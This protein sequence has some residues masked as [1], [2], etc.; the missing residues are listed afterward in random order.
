M[1]KT[2]VLIIAIMT[3]LGSS[4]VF[5]YGDYYKGSKRGWYWF[6]QRK[7]P[8]K[9]EEGKQE[10][11]LVSN[12]NATEELQRFS[13]ELDEAKAAMI[14]RPNIENTAKFIEYQ[15]EMFAKAD[16]VTENWQNA[17]LVYPHLNIA[18]D[19]PISHAGAKIK[20]RAEAE[21][22]KQLLNA[23]SK[24]FI[25]LFFYEGN[26]I[27]CGHFAEVLEVFAK[28]YGFKVS[29]VTIDGKQIS[30]FPSSRREDLV[31]KL[32]VRYF[33][34]VYAYSES[35][36]VVVPISSEFL[37]IDELENHAVYV[38]SKLKERL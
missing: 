10:E 18:R 6:E 32:N 1:N 25:L 14:M 5:G 27:Y 30:K 22:N 31:S 17:M 33:P 4:E 38:A 13:Q 35:L 3:I 8:A 34:S 11:K 15:N 28:R 37:A 36:G 16:V 9:E 24:K 19:I 26:C 23:F 21:S 7:V 12:K 29:S 20:S 2:A